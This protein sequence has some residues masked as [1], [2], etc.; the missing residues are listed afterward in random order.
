MHKYLVFICSFLSP[1]VCIRSLSHQLICLLIPPSRM[2]TKMYINKSCL[3]LQQFAHK[4]FIK[5]RIFV[6]IGHY[7][8]LFL[9]E[10][11][12]VEKYK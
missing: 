5:C 10:V 7:I 3:T 12:K 11:N 6:V 4:N 1:I 9:D 2:Q 8:D